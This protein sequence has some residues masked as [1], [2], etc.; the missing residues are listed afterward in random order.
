MIVAPSRWVAH[1]LSTVV[2]TDVGFDAVPAAPVGREGWYLTRPGFAWGGIRVAA[3]WAGG[4]RALAA[5][6]ASGVAARRQP[7]PLR[8]ANLGRADVAAWSAGLALAHAAREIDEGRATGREA[9]VL[10]GRTRAVVAEAA[11]TV[12]REIGHALGPA[13]LA[14]EEAH[15]R[16]V[17]DLT[18][19][20]RQ[21]HAERDLAALADLTLLP[22]GREP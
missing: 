12:L 13:P 1:G 6:L 16:R 3:C 5:S 17:A 22:D 11:E 9:A 7:D 2:T 14:F 10:A 8:L 15:A 19:Y 20:L 4:T 18:L 21:H